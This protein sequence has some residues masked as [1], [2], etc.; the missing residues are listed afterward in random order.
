MTADLTPVDRLISGKGEIQIPIQYAEARQILLFTQVVRDATNKSVNK[1]FNPDKSFYAH[2]C[3]CYDE[4]VLQTYDLSFDDQV[5]EIHSNMSAQLLLAL[6][7]MSAKLF[8]PSPIADFNYLIFLANNI[9]F[10]CFSSVAIRLVL[11]GKKLEFCDENDLNPDPPP[12]PPARLP[13][14]PPDTGLLVSPP[15]P[16][17]PNSENTNPDS[18]DDIEE[19]EGSQECVQYTVI[20]S[21]TATSVGGP[22][23]VV[24]GQV[25]RVWGQ[26][27][28]ISA[29]R[30]PDNDPEIYLFC[31]GVVDFNQECGEFKKYGIASANNAGLGTEY[32]NPVINSIT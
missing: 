7:C 31:R 1:T 4:Y 2:I 32:T 17:D 11:K 10:E 27:G 13:K 19:E 9:K 22:P 14:V 25:I 30:Q 18:L 8:N 29:G 12:E 20:Y 28:S 16:D 26:V 5:F 24:S 21:Y 6:K 15:Y 23:N 3:F